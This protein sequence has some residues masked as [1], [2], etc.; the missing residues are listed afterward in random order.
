VDTRQLFKL[1]APQGFGAP[2]VF[3]YERKYVVSEPTADAIRRFIAPYL[4]P[5]EHMKPD[6]PRG[7][8][9]FSLYFDTPLLTMYRQ[10]VE[11]IRSR[12]KLR[13]RFYDALEQSL[14]LFE[15]KSRQADSIHKQRAAVPKS[16]VAEFMAGK[17]LSAEWLIGRSDKSVQ[18]LAEFSERCDRVRA[19]PTAFVS[20]WREAYVSR[21]PDDIRVTI[22][23]Q[24]TAR[25]GRFARSLSLPE[26]ATTAAP[27]KVVLELKNSGRAPTWMRDLV[28]TFK[29]QR[30]S[31]PKYV[32]CV[33][34]MQTATAA[35]VLPLEKA[36]CL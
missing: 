12:Y 20:Y 1:L 2:D 30:I 28:R 26:Q 6:E 15:I 32:L 24:L 18:A 29:L 33:D 25:D 14:A 22:D 10:T 23:R 3:R 35:H 36:A 31:F 19:V 7:Y 5:D 21:Q 9:V 34:A 27:N 11:G 8:E 4:A 13:I 17:P 16:A